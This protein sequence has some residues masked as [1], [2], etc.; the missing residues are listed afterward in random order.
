MHERY[1]YLA[2]IMSLVCAF[3]AIRLWPAPI[4]VEFGS[5]S[6]YHAYLMNRY[7]VDLR[8][9][10]AAYAVAG[11]LILRALFIQLEKPDSRG[12]LDHISNNSN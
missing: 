10:A 9:G 12:I 1:F 8:I 3:I 11:L 6:G 5:W 7:I 2:D 4:L